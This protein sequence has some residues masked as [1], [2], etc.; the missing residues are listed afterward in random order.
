MIVR[1]KFV[2]GDRGSPK[3]SI[4]PNEVALRVFKQTVILTGPAPTR[5]DASFARDDS[6]ER[7]A[8]LSAAFR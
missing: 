1:A 5:R 2:T 6:S 4:P 7:G 3:S 8:A